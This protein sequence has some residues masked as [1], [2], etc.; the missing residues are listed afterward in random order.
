M[1]SYNLLITIGNL[2]VATG[3]NTD[4]NESNNEIKINISKLELVLEEYKN[5]GFNINDYELNKEKII[6]LQIQR[7]TLIEKRAL[8]E[9]ESNIQFHYFLKPLLIIPV[10]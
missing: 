2:I 7:D 9:K 6:R 5:T 10:F 4:C 3:Y 1:S 8:L